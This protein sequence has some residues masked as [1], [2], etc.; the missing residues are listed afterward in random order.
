MCVGVLCGVVCVTCVSSEGSEPVD[1]AARRGPP[2]G[3]SPGPGVTLG[4]GV[5]HRPR[6]RDD[7]HCH[8]SAGGL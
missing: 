6:H 4:L 7:H 3:T 8:L 1:I 2:H 5:W